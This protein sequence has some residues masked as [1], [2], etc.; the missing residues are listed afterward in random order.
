M[1]L[2]A[3]I[4]YHDPGQ[5]VAK[6]CRQL[7]RETL[8]RSKASAVTEFSWPGVYFVCADTRVRHHAPFLEEENSGVL[9]L[10]GE[11]LLGSGGDTES[12]EGV[13]RVA[14]S[15]NHNGVWILRSARGTFCLA[16]YTA[17][18]HRLLLA[19]D[20]VGIRP[21]Y[22]Y[23]DGM[24]VIFSTAL[25]VL[26][27]LSRQ[28]QLT[29][30]LEA[31][32]ELNTL[33]FPLGTCTAYRE[34]QCLRGGEALTWK[35][36]TKRK[37]VYWRWDQVPEDTDSA[38]DSA[39]RLHEIFLEAVT[40]RLG[41]N[42]QAQA[43]LSGGLD[44]R[45]V[46]TALLE[47]GVGVRTYNIS[48]AGSYDQI[49]GA[50]YAAH[51]GT[52]HHEI[53]LS[54]AFDGGATFPQVLARVSASQSHAGTQT[55]TERPRVWWSGD[56]GS[57][58]VGRV[59]LNEAMVELLRA[60]R[61]T[62]AA[63]EFMRHNSIAFPTGSLRREAGRRF[64]AHFLRRLEAEIARFNCTDPG[65][66]FFL[67]LLEND[68]RRHMAAFYEDVDINMI[69]YEM[70]FF[71]GD[72]LAAATALNL[73]AT[74]RHRFYVRDWLPTF[75][76]SIAQVVW[77]AYPGH[78][79]CPVPGPERGTPQWQLAGSGRAHLTR[80]AQAAS[81]FRWASSGCLPAGMFSR[82]RLAGIGV[83]ALLGGRDY[84]YLFKS[85]ERLSYY[86]GVCAGRT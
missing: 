28:L 9:L 52:P 17:E 11:P 58:G 73:D 51:V 14:S 5:A 65:K 62:A 39:R 29:V 27:S 82:V 13:R 78:E 70:P 31:V 10:A 35:D 26:E 38:D 40:L 48:M 37:D 42:R 53:T 7:L 8:D 2:F 12:S 72:V 64:E 68:Q 61:L 81:A 69:E 49:I 43:L 44:S 56:G 33:G 85:I 76:R 15:L 80:G 23:D 84:S 3:G 74:L 36:G 47:L 18:H 24:R 25:R 66:A 32:L 41:G 60:G 59:Y 30:D 1:S 20:K 67:F 75:G 45:C 71:D 16:E 55:A 79:P 21:V 6:E 34:I 22:Y 19:V 46:V 86:L 4:Y 77:Q 63:R 57:V 50:A 54:E 83:S